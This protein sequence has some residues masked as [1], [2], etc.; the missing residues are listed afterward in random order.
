MATETLSPA[1]TNLDSLELSIRKELAPA[2]YRDHNMGFQLLEADDTE[3]KASGVRVF[4]IGEKLWLYAPIFF[5]SGE[6][7]G[8]ELLYIKNKDVFVPFDE[9]WVNY[10][11]S[12]EPLTLGSPGTR[13]EKSTEPDFTPFTRIPTSPEGLSTGTV[14]SAFAK[15][16]RRS[17][18][19]ACKHFD[20][21]EMVKQADES[22]KAGLC[23]FL[24]ADLKVAEHLVNRFPELIELLRPIEKQAQEEPQNE[25]PVSVKVIV[26]AG[27][28]TSDER[29][30][31]LTQ[32][33]AVRDGRPEEQKARLT[34]VSQLKLVTPG[35]TGFYRVVTA[36]G[37]VEMLVVLHGPRE[38]TSVTQDSAAEKSMLQD[39]M[40]VVRW[41]D[42][43][44]ARPSG[45]LC[46]VNDPNLVTRAHWETRYNEL[47]GKEEVVPG[48]GE[49]LFIGPNPGETFG[50][51]YVH[52]VVGLPNGQHEIGTSKGSCLVTTSG[53]S[54]IFQDGRY[55][56]PGTWKIVKLTGGKIVTP[57]PTQL[58]AS[59]DTLLQVKKA[60]SSFVLDGYKGRDYAQRY[61]HALKLLME[62][63]GA[64][65]KEARRALQ[66][67]REVGTELF[68]I[69][70][71]QMP[72][73]A[74]AP[75]MPPMPMSEMP[76]DP[77]ARRAVQLAQRALEAGQADVVDVGAMSA[78]LN[79]SDSL[80]YIAKYMGDL[81][82]AVD[83]LGRI[84][85]VIYW[86]YDEFV[87]AFGHSETEVLRDRLVSIFKDLGALILELKEK[88]ASPLD[89]PV[90][91]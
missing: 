43:L 66:L 84:L 47:P 37:P 22:A 63:Y 88:T 19:R 78:L 56:V 82:T 38:V 50:P 25:L 36:D 69:K 23:R 39:R 87:E 1:E 79:T 6:I 73:A 11:L 65:E 31:V 85:F 42:K 89:L 61:S 74:E 28:A 72:P 48:S 21:C 62:K 64:G 90:V 54:L 46:A 20:L 29:P 34:P 59:S 13:S 35:E 81:L 58:L 55:I 10:L 67:A 2:L 41:E 44:Y 32:G 70:E 75:A 3:E 80:Q 7:M 30:Q 14:K 91:D 4:L 71:G 83:R 26:S 68:L 16:A 24:L 17:Y 12:K 15:W 53:G 52:D 27:E 8:D 5:I 51:T 40:D 76:E 33:Y 49:Y 45:E 77:G 9:D 60:G 57:G 86:N 18:E